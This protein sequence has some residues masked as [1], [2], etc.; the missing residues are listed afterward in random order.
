[1]AIRLGG[2]GLHRATL[3]IL[4]AGVA[5]ATAVP[6]ARAQAVPGG[7]SNERPRDTGCSTSLPGILARPGADQCGAPERLPDG[8]GI[9][10]LPDILAR[11][12]W[13]FGGSIAR[14]PQ[15]GDDGGAI[16]RVPLDPDSGGG[17]VAVPTP[18]PGTHLPQTADAIP[19]PQPR[20]DPN[21]P[22][23]PDNSSGGTQAASGGNAAPTP[24]A[25]PAAVPPVAV[26]GAHVPDEV[27]VTIDGDD[28]TA[29]EIAAAFGLELRA[30]RVSALAGATVARLG[31]PDG[32][33]VGLVLAQLAGDPRATRRVP[34][35]IYTLQQAPAVANY[36]FQ[37]ILLDRETASGD[38]IDIAV[39]DTAADETHPALSGVI[40]ASYDALPDS[41]V[42]ERGHGTS[43]SGLIAG[44]GDNAGVAPGARLHHARAFESG[45]STMYA[46]IDALD[47]SAGQSVRIINMSFTGPRN[48]LFE[49]ICATARGAG[50]VLVAAA[51]NNGPGAPYAYPAAYDDVIAVTATDDGD[52]L[53]E[54]ANRGPYVLVSAPGV[55]LLAPVPGGADA[56]TG[57]SFAAAIVSGA[58]A[59]ALRE[60]PSASP[61]DIAA[62]LA[63]TATD[64]GP[65]GRDDDYGYG[66][67][68]TKAAIARM[69]GQ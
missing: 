43:I 51:G 44:V 19:L 59:N 60:A 35:H 45:T 68:N 2:C 25:I 9:V 16:P 49:E 55:D 33:P 31:I 8:R 23:A 5:V 38:D 32:R 66:L 65:A 6:A 30:S 24:P 21:A 40:V 10:Y 42:Q 13:D 67:I 27:L 15:D 46:L 36:A 1:M 17:T 39:I 50:M 18:R 47:W 57:T 11:L 26:S 48:D 54:R 14:V 41:P 34:N 20:P 52:V 37:H 63:G 58:I 28:A 12:P 53:M 62:I 56:V 3:A 4:L 61:E 29:A 7:Q 69:T 22:D 64:L